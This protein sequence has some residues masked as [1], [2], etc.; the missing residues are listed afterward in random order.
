[1][2]IKKCTKCANYMGYFEYC[3][4][5]MMVEDI[6]YAEKCDNYNEIIVLKC[7]LLNIGDD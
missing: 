6:Y 5:D 1:M 3:G 4:F 2:K 7:N